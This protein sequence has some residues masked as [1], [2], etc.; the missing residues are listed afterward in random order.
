METP[1]EQI[2]TRITRKVPDFTIS[3]LPQPTKEKFI[4]LSE[5]EFCSDYGMTL[6]FLFNY[7]E[8][9]SKF[10]YLL[11]RMEQLELFL[12]QPSEQKKKPKFLMKEEKP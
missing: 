11:Q 9:G 2:V 7:W 5:E 12:S 3:R 8:Q 10:D 4:K 1:Q 6:C